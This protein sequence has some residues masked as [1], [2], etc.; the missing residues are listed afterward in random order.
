MSFTLCT[1]GAIG[2][3]LFELGEGLPEQADWERTENKTWADQ[4]D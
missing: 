1:G 3:G 4:T 2:R